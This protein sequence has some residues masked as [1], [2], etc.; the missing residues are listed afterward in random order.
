MVLII[1]YGEKE[2]IK[3]CKR[4]GIPHRVAEIEMI[5]GDV[6]NDKGTFC[7]EIK[8]SFSDFWASM[9]DGRIPNQEQKL[10]EY[11]SG[12][13]YVFVEYGCLADLA[14]MHGKDRNW[15]YSKFGE[16]ENWDC[17]FR[18]FD[19]MEDLAWK[20]YWL[21]QKLGTE[22]KVRDVQV[23]IYNKTVAQKVLAQFPG[24]SKKGEEMLKE[25]KTLGNVLDD[26]L[27]N[28]GKKLSTIKGVA[29]LPKGKILST[30]I[31]EI[32]KNHD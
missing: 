1:F 31:E 14:D 27:N 19:D 5:T 28:D 18:E 25:L 9:V 2:L 12:G 6:T 24:I 11:Y 30:M 4:L 29:P 15:I 21:D 8:M 7:A 3:T 32:N 17:K 22:R 23:R 26:L 10:Y 16:I 13:R 20:L